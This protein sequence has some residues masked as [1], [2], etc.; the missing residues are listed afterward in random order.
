MC[1]HLIAVNMQ[2]S[3]W[4]C[5]IHFALNYVLESILF[6]YVLFLE[7]SYSVFLFHKVDRLK[8]V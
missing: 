7:W 4:K 8:D 6:T 3:V 5:Y 1:F 2:L